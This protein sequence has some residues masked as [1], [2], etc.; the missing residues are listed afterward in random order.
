METPV[1]IVGFENVMSQQGNPGIRVYG[2]R[3]VPADKGEGYESVREYIN[4]K[5][6]DYK[7]VLGDVVIFVMRGQYVDRV[8]KVG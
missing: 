3:P 4:P 5:H 6:C 2:Q 1:T 8:I 7:P